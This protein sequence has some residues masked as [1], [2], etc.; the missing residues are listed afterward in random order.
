M[1]RVF[2]LSLFI[3]ACIHSFAQDSL[4][5]PYQK[6]PTYPPV[7]LLLPD[8]THFYTKAD[9]PEKK[10]IM[11][12]LFNPQCEHC[13]QEA[14]NLAKNLDKFKKIHIVMAT[15]APLFEMK[16][17][18]KKYQLDGKD[19]IVFAQDTNYF[20]LSFF[21]LHNLPFHAF[22]GKKRELISVAEGSMTIEKIVAELSK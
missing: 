8:S 9:L 6:F 12:V 10:K 15:T 2:L 18:A 14:E 22:Y 3:F 19:N 20:L 17:F 4:L 5:A 21:N 1:K 13:Q 16:G 11:L 7:K